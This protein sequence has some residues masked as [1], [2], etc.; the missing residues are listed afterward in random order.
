M[1]KR[2]WFRRKRGV[3]ALVGLISAASLH[4]QEIPVDS[5]LPTCVD[6][7]LRLEV[8]VADPDIVTPIGLAID[9]DDSLYVIESHTHLRAADYTGPDSD[10]IK[11]LRRSA[12]N[13]KYKISTFADG[14]D[15]A[16]NLAFSPRGDLFVVCA[17]EVVSFPKVNGRLDPSAREVVLR[18]ETQERYAHN[19]LLGITFDRHGKMYVSR[20]NTGGRA[21]SV[22]GTDGTLVSGYGDGG[23]VLVCDEGGGN[24]EEF[25]TGFW[26]PFDLKFDTFGR[27][28]LVD[29][30]PDARGPN[31][32]VHVVPH[33]DYGY[34]SLYGGGGNHPFQGWDGSLPGTLPYVS[35]VGEAPSG[36]IDARRSSFSKRYR[37]ALLCTIW[38]ENS[39]ERIDVAPKEGRLQGINRRQW[40]TG[41]KNFRPVAL[42]AD[43]RGDLFFTDWV[44]VDYPNHG[45]GKIWRVSSK[46]S[47]K[48]RMLPIAEF[49]EYASD[50]F[51][52]QTSLGIEQRLKMPSAFVRHE[53]VIELAG[54]GT[55]A[56]DLLVHSDPMVRLGALLAA[57]RASQLGVADLEKLLAD[58]DLT[59]R[60]AALHMVAKRLDPRLRPLLDLAI[61]SGQVD[62]PLFAA[63]YAAVQNLQPAFARAVKN[64]SQDR[65]KDIKPKTDTHAL[66]S[67]VEDSAKPGNVRAMAIEYLKP[68]I[69]SVAERL[70]DI[71]VKFDD[72]ELVEG[73][74][75]RWLATFLRSMQSATLTPA[76]QRRALRLAERLETLPTADGSVKIAA[77]EFIAEHGSPD[78]ERLVQIAKTGRL[79]DGELE[80]RGKR[81]RALVAYAVARVLRRQSKISLAV[82]DIVKK[83]SSLSD[84]SADGSAYESAVGEQLKL[85]L[86]ETSA[87]QQWLAEISPQQNAKWIELADSKTGDPDR[88][89]LVFNS[90]QLGCA[91]CHSVSGRGGLLGPDLRHV[92][93]SKSVRQIAEAIVNPSADFPPQ[94]QAWTV[95]DLDGNVYRG[96]QMDH[97]AN[98]AIEMLSEKGE[99]VRVEGQDV[100]TYHASPNSLMPEGLHRQLTPTEF[101]DMLAY[102]ATMQ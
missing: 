50:P 70:L 85:A 78:W 81:Q 53:A 39:I 72:N 5:E 63:W 38:N 80:S 79:V 102:L 57:E 31:R 1:D 13:S 26:N 18:L 3:I 48:G 84:E 17:R 40:I 46:P 54:T 14:L 15:A 59:V 33:G 86:L 73:D 35:G 6:P 41:G 4:G 23:S 82:Y 19:C 25:A 10:R 99:T 91:R 12:D 93:A 37:D 16:M 96:I 34:K 68:Q 30:D 21:Y 66:L 87:A 47:T 11:V 28:L 71:A 88:G 22:V 75:G 52:Q 58:D 56:G 60:R 94:Y 49:D 2:S 27:L 97:K 51:S 89:R 77:V 32:L 20:G 62:A 90:P 7:N 65:S 36:L 24:V 67:V 92:A 76:V 9:S 8:V 100:D 43:S 45:R 95:A 42:A 74:E 55:A 44:L 98:G 101:L 64:R 61:S 69:E 29:N 83:Q